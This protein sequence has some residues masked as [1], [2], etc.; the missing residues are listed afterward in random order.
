[1]SKNLLVVASLVL[2]AGCEAGPLDGTWTVR[3]ADYASEGCFIPG[4][5]RLPLPVAMTIAGDNAR[6]EMADGVV[7]SLE[8]D[9]SGS[10]SGPFYGG[11]IEAG[12]DGGMTIHL[13]AVV[14]PG[15]ECWI[16]F[17]VVRS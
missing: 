13:G 3:E 10:M 17:Y 2:F 14:S 16:E 9:G 12:D 5:E 11:M 7:V 1:M 6:V 8:I 15:I 4:Y